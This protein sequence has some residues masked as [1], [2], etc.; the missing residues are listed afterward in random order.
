MQ[1]DF[2]EGRVCLKAGLMLRFVVLEQSGGRFANF[3]I[4]PWLSQQMFGACSG[5]GSQAKQHLEVICRPGLPA[6]AEIYSDGF[7]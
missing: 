5:R 2:Q 4:T 7:C 6:W 1:C 3:M